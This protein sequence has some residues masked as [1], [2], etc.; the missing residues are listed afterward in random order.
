MLVS[1][2]NEVARVDVS[3]TLDRV[4]RSLGR[5]S[6]AVKVFDLMRHGFKGPEIRQCLGI[7][8]AIYDA[9]YKWIF[10][11]CKREGYRRRPSAR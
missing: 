2:V 1:P 7:S 5:R 10:R 3:I 11:T 6:D 8:K 4:R 9:V